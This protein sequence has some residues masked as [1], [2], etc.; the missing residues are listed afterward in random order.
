MPRNNS[1]NNIGNTGNNA[2][3]NTRNNN[4]VE[5]VFEPNNANNNDTNNATNNVVGKDELPQLHDS[6]GGSHV[7]NV[8]QL[9][10]EDFTSWKDRFLVYLDGLEPYF[11]SNLR[12]WTILPKSTPSTPKNF[13]PRPQKYWT[14][15]DRR[16]FN[17]DKRL[18]SII[19]S[20]EGPSET[21][22]TKIATL[23]LKFIAFKA[24]EGEKEKETY[25]MLK[26]FDSKVEE[27]TRS[28]NKFLADLNA[29][30]H[31][32]AILAYPN[33]FYKRSEDEDTTTI[34]AFMTIAEDEPVVGKTNAMSNQLLTQ[35]VPGN[36][37][38]ALSGRGKRK[39]VISSKDVVF[40][41]SENSL[42]KNSLNVT[43]DTE[44]INDNQEPLP[45][46]PKFLGAE[47]IG[48]S[49]DVITSTDLIQTFKVSDKTKQVTEKESS[50]KS[51]K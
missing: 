14:A 15:I 44:S 25:T 45:P 1:N 43:S 35:Q 38:H 50:V 24:L 22:D 2:G 23:R 13:L 46:F 3:N 39:E 18:K 29:E 40:I 30:F 16:L 32:R 47:P 10:V 28:S 19:I 41:K 42:S 33:R 21:R 26:I 6:K 9:D 37:I 11:T 12:K 49:T 31:D 7:T 36:I 34:K 51:V 5:N 20:H 4:M 8:P 48:T 27:D 17:Q